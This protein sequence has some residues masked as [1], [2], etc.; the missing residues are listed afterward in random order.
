MAK[1][2]VVLDRFMA[3]KYQLAVW[4]EVL[5]FLGPYTVSYDGVPPAKEIPTEMGEVPREHVDEVKKLVDEKTQELRE[6][7]SK[8]GET[9]I[10]DDGKKGKKST[11]GPLKKSGKEG[12]K[13][14]PGGNGGNGKKPTRLTLPKAR[15][16]GKSGG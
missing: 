12:A 6:E 5:N 10:K 3:L 1:F 16:R 14:S 9:E 8:L 11:K 4:D 7:L 15:G 2:A 13:G